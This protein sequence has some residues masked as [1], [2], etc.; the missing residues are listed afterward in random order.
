MSDMKKKNLM[1]CAL[2]AIVLNLS[3]AGFS[4]FADCMDTCTCCCKDEQITE[5]VS[6][7]CSSKTF[8]VSNDCC[9][10]D[11]YHEAH[12]SAS[13]Q[14]FRSVIGEFRENVLSKHIFAE[15]SGISCINQ[16]SPVEIIY[17][18]FKPPIA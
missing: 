4:S 2:A 15:I 6:D 8:V 11:H 18:I 7:C 12:L 9:G 16:K 3:F 10:T 1:L 14:N 5:V 13:K 17:L